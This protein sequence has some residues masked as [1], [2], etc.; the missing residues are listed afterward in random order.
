[1][2]PLASA[3]RTSIRKS[4][5]QEVRAYNP[6]TREAQREAWSLLIRSCLKK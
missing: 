3:C 5:A 2:T 6:S 1:M 4:L